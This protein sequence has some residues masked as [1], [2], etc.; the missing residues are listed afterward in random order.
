MLI[1][2]TVLFSSLLLG[3]RYGRQQLLGV[4]GVLLGVFILTV[5]PAWA[6]PTTSSF[7]K[8]G[9]NILL[10]SAAYALMGLG[11]V[12]KEM[13]LTGYQNQLKQTYGEGS[14]PAAEKK[15]DVALFVTGGTAARTFTVLLGWPLYL[16]VTGQKISIL[17]SLFQSFEV[18]KQPSVL[19]LALIYWICNALLT[20]MAILLVQRSSAAA[21]VL[22][23]VVALPLSCFLFCFP[24]PFL[25]PQAFQWRF[26][27]S[28][29]LVVVGNFVYNKASTVTSFK[30]TR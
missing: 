19:L 17:E 6:G 2:F 22:A 4:G 5:G 16:H 30:Q 7:P 3:R 21:V 8:L 23:N 24:L 27:V 18:F 13:V 12:I 9:F 25:A 20:V 26:A 14:V 10:C 28:L 15:F 11:M 1:P 29:L